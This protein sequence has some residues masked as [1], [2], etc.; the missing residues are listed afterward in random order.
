MLPS[1]YLFYASFFSFLYYYYYL[2]RFAVIFFRS[3]FKSFFHGCI[4]VKR[5]TVM[6]LNYIDAL[7]VDAILCTYALYARFSFIPSLQVLLLALRLILHLLHP[8][9]IHASREDLKKVWMH[10]AMFVS[11]N[12]LSGKPFS[13]FSCV[14][15]SLG[16]LVNRKHFPVK[17]KFGLVSRKVFS[18]DVD[19][20]RDIICF[21]WECGQLQNW[22][23]SWCP[24]ASPRITLS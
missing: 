23:R 15:L 6:N 20:L 10:Q 18:L 1:L 16:K 3:S 9:K 22:P 4:Q 7:L 13:K 24:K 19:N 21:I 11:R 12:S 5:R 14:C 2:G 8:L 17:E